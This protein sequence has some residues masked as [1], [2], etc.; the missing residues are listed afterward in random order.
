M[1]SC[2]AFLLVGCRAILYAQQGLSFIPVSLRL[3]EEITQQNVAFSGLEIDR[4]DDATAS[5]S[6]VAH[7][8]HGFGFNRDYFSNGKLVD[9]VA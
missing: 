3:D 2:C 6:M 8:G 9:L 7:E 5:A 4:T 1:L